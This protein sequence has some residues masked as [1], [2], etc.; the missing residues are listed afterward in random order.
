M[1]EEKNI[2]III[3]L[4]SVIFMCGSVVG[5][6]YFMKR[7]ELYGG[8][9]DYLNSYLKNE[10]V[11]KEK[12]TIFKNTLNM[13]LIMLSF[14]FLSGFFK[15]GFLLMSVAVIK[16]GF[17]IGFTTAAFIKVLG[18]KGVAV[19]LTYLPSFL[20]LIPGLICFCAISV[21]FSIHKNKINKKI[22][23]NYILLAI[24]TVTIF[25]AAAIAEAYLTTIFIKKIVGFM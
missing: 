7:F 4:F 13:N 8:L 3:M 14:V 11:E 5:S 21:M 22:I 9:S 19:S 10:F 15:A 1:N 20:F 23:F 17:V 25:C 18:I 2:K 12:L 6:L 24:F 16:K